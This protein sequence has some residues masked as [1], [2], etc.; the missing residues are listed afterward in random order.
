MGLCV[1]MWL[2]QAC[3]WEIGSDE[4]LL[5]PDSPTLTSLGLLCL[6]GAWLRLS[7]RI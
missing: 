2:R 7:E 6:V 3:L 5:R 1:P 4:E